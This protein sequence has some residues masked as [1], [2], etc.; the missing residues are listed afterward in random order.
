MNWCSHGR[1]QRLF[2][3]EEANRLRDGHTEI[4]DVDSPN[5]LLSFSL[6]QFLFVHG[7]SPSHCCEEGVFG[8][9]SADSV[10]SQFREEKLS[11]Y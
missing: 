3:A 1:R 4:K 2:Q 11:K 5:T 6:Y 9:F 8:I 7:L 10:V